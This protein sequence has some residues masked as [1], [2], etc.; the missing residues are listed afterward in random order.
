MSLIKGP[1]QDIDTFRSQVIDKTRCI[2]GSG[3][4]PRDIASIVS[5]YFIKFNVLAFKFKA[6]HFYNIL[7]NNPTGMEWDGIVRKLNNNYLSL[8]SQNLWSPKSTN[9]KANSNDFTVLHSKVNKLT[10][11]VGAQAPRGAGRK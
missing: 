8:K 5:Q 1:G 4:S 3:S 7:D 2:V 9:S 10:S 6:L 11:Q